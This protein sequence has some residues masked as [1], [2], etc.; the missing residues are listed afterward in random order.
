[1]DKKTTQ[2]KTFS[3]RV[4][5]A[6]LSIPSGRVTT[7]GRIAR[8]AGGG[9]SAARSITRILSKAN[10]KNIPFY[11]IV[12]TD[13]RI[14]M[15]QCSGTVSSGP[16]SNPERPLLSKTKQVVGGLMSDLNKE[17]MKLYKKEGI[18]I[19]KEKIKDFDDILFEFE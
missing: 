12:Y 3:D 8:A 15:K 18:E 2:F 9:P 13:G 7:Y 1:M 10:T 4:V 16:G 19:E 14:W 17:R 6:A 5:R 11:R